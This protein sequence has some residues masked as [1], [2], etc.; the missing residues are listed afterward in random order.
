MEYGENLIITGV[1]ECL[2]LVYLITPAALWSLTSSTAPRYES[3][4]RCPI[5]KVCA[6]ESVP[7]TLWSSVCNQVGLLNISANRSFD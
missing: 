1:F 2:C 4:N 7:E 3:V 6:H 5:P